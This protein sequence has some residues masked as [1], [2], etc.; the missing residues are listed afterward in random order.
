MRRFLNLCLTGKSLVSP[1]L[2]EN[3][4]IDN[5]LI[6]EIETQKRYEIAQCVLMPVRRLVLPV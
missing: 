1:N 3:V 2:A 5:I 4:T 6:F